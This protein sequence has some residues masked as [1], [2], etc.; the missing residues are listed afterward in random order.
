MGAWEKA[1]AAPGNER[2]RG[3]LANKEAAS[4]WSSLA[5]ATDST[6]DWAPTHVPAGAPPAAA[7]PRA[8]PA[9]TR[10]G[11]DEEAEEASGGH[12]CGRLARFA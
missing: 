12:S 1:D 8:S 5:P 9:V 6:V 3:S 4:D 2:Q 7:P 11:D 10:D